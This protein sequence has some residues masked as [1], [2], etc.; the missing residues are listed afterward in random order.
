MVSHL[1]ESDEQSITVQTPARKGPALSVRQAQAGP[2]SRESG[3]LGPGDSRRWVCALAL[4]LLFVAPAVDQGQG[5]VLGV[6]GVEDVSST[7]PEDGPL[8]GRNGLGPSTAS[9][10]PRSDLLSL[11]HRP[12]HRRRVSTKLGAKSG[13]EPM[14]TWS[15]HARTDPVRKPSS[16]PP[17]FDDAIGGARVVRVPGEHRTVNLVAPDPFPLLEQRAVGQGLDRPVSQGQLSPGHG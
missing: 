2:D 5:W 10:N 6:A 9:T 13:L 14:C 17:L 7:L 4:L 1:S 15:Y 16:L 11:F 8:P 3:T 12:A